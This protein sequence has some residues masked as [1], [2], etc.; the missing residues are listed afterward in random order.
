MV[1]ANSATSSPTSPEPSVVLPCALQSVARLRPRTCADA[2]NVP[3]GRW[4]N[5]RA[6]GIVER[7][8]VDIVEQQSRR[9][10]RAVPGSRPVHRAGRRRPAAARRQRRP[11][12]AR[13]DRR[14]RSTC[15][16]GT[17]H[18]ILRTLQRRRLRRAG[19]TLRQ[20]PARRRRCCTSAPA[21]STSTSCGPR[22]INWADPLAARSGEAVGS[23]R[24]GRARCCVVHHVFRPD[25]TLQT[26][27]RS[28][29]C[30]RC[31]PARWARCCSPT[32][33]VRH[34]AGPDLEPYTR[35][36]VVPP[37]DARRGR[38]AA[39]RE[40]RLGRRG[41]GDDRR[42][43]PAI[44]APIRGLRWP[45][46]RRASASPARSSELFGDGRR[47][48]P[49]RT[50]S[51]CVADVREAVRA[52]CS[53]RRCAARGTSGRDGHDRAVRRRRSTRAPPRPGASLFD[54][55]GRL[56]LG[57]PARAPA[58]LPA[59][60]AG[61]STTRWRSGATCER[62]VPGRAA[63]GRARRRT[64][65]PRSASP[66]SARP[67]CSGTGAPACRWAGPSSGRTPAPTR[68]SAE[69]V[70]DGPARRSSE[71]CGLP[72]G[73]LLRRPAAALAARPRAR[74]CGPAPSAAR[75]CSARWRPG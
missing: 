54:R 37:R 57:G 72:L 11:A 55:R 71:L 58:A 45:G 70:A 50:P 22:A 48:A 34:A 33:P 36:T 29:R 44:A 30:C 26:L 52:R 62:L 75:C 61:S 53:Q 49:A 19:P 69:L 15:A 59:A 43:R 38:L 4:V 40:R 9:S 10:V 28:A 8:A 13:R 12:R 5:V 21:T 23:A 32:T 39:V 7:T 25:D 56:R 14:G 2:R 47:A 3:S 68:S 73:H 63:P 31:T 24:P 35:R 17:V 60:R 42:A 51:S 65:S 67:P 27:R 6:F 41:R 64:R 66:T 16:K 20:V 1:P 74:G 46:G 18:G